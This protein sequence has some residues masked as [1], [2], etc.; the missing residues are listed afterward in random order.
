MKYTFLLF[1]LSLLTHYVQAQ[2]TKLTLNPKELSMQTG[3][4]TTVSVNVE[5]ADFAYQLFLSAVHSDL[6]SS[7]A[8]NFRTNPLNPPYVTTMD[9]SI[10]GAPAPG[11]HQLVIKA[12]NGPLV[13]NDTCYITIPEK[14]CEWERV[15][16]SSPNYEYA[17]S[18][19]ID[20]K[21]NIWFTAGN[22]FGRRSPE[23][24]TTEY[25][26]NLG[27]D[28]RFFKIAID[29]ND[30]V[31]LSTLTYDGDHPKGLLYF[32]QSQYIH[33]T[34]DNS[35]LPDSRI[36]GIVC[37][38]DNVLW[39]ATEAGI[40][41]YDRTFWTIY[42]TAN[43]PLISN[44]IRTITIDKHN[45]KWAAY[46]KNEDGTGGY[47]VV[48]YSGQDWQIYTKDSFCLPYGPL[49]A[50]VVSNI[51]IDSSDNIWLTTY[52]YY[53]IIKATSENITLYGNK[54]ELGS[55]ANHVVLSKNDC[56]VVSE[57]DSEINFYYP[58]AIK[59]AGN[60]EVWYCGSQ[61][62]NTTVYHHKNNSWEVYSPS[63]SALP[64]TEASD[65]ALGN[66]NLVAVTSKKSFLNHNQ[67][68]YL[69]ILNCE[70]P[71]VTSARDAGSDMQI[72]LYPNP[73]QNEL[74]ISLQNLDLSPEDIRVIDV[75]G[76]A[77]PAAITAQHGNFYK[78]DVT[79][80]VSGIYH[81]TFQSNGKIVSQRFIKI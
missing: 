2:T 81:I 58:K 17:Y 39:L 16:L 77:I 44:S 50:L 35:Q 66:D 37:D 3:E 62:E 28:Y 55:Y 14:D 40:V 29:K 76:N 61:N 13:F 7:A 27:F 21:N 60:N 12:A 49:G 46:P 9:I 70:E 23:G 20:S 68:P 10:Q 71:I 48:R 64:N 1:A 19:A 22:Y 36:H 65:I 56:S 31:W 11:R 41:E 47:E 15:S 8:I 63:N 74:F 75:H 59:A 67:G 45:N 24:I 53:S 52:G 4:T 42:S 26:P 25:R 69:N 73:V 6:G 38:N 33:Y 72:S 57:D 51:V 32:N 34:S 79:G 78:I 80:L 30:N 5:N 43:T 18:T 54:E